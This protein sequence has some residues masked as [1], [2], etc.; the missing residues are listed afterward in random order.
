[1][2]TDKKDKIIIALIIGIVI[3]L[4]KNFVNNEKKDELVFKM[5]VHQFL[6]N[7]IIQAQKI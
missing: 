2:E 1:M 6:L 3:I 5:Q 4:S 7:L